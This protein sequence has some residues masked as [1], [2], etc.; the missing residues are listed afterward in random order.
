M[1]T[2]DN[3]IEFDGNVSILSNSLTNIFPLLFVQNRDGGWGSVNKNFPLLKFCD[4][5][6]K[7]FQ[8]AA[9]LED[10]RNFALVV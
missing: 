8:A 9:L 7:N 6:S 4:T 5:K 3:T 1:Y 2:G 10:K